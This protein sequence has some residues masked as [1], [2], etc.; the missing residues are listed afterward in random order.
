M[1]GLQIVGSA[2]LCGQCLQKSNTIDR[3]TMP[4]YYE[5][6][7]TTLLFQ[8]KFY[9]QLACLSFFSYFLVAKLKQRIG[10]L[11]EVIIPV[12]LHKNRL[13]T[14]GYNQ[15]LELAKK[16]SRLLNIRLD[17]HCCRRVKITSSQRGLNAKERRKNVKNAFSVK[18]K[19]I[20]QHIALVDDV[21]TTGATANEVAKCLKEKGA[22][23]VEVWCC[24]RA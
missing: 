19:L 23:T 24:A 10:P 15:S 4:F 8:L 12:P 7:I 2:I 16:L 3:A 17:R 1:C 22:S 13:K 11:P 5:K 18:R 6:P 20:Y 21:M 9:D 14:R